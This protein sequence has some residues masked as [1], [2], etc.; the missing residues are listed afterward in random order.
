VASTNPAIRSFLARLT[1]SAS[2]SRSTAVKPV[3]D[4]SY[5]CVF[6]KE[7]KSDRANLAGNTDSRI[8]LRKK[9]PRRHDGHDEVE[10]LS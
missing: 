4:E 5:A 9:E 10:K 3:L 7:D 1:L 8:P 6:A 2:D